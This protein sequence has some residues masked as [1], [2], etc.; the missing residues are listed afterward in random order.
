MKLK[1]LIIVLLFGTMIGGAF[2]PCAIDDAGLKKDIYVEIL[3]GAYFR[4]TSE[5]LQRNVFVGLGPGVP[6]SIEMYQ[7]GKKGFNEEIASREGRVSLQWGDL[8]IEENAQGWSEA[9]KGF[10]FEFELTAATPAGQLTFQFEDTKGSFTALLDAPKWSIPTPQL[11]NYEEAKAIDPEKP[12]TFR[13]DKPTQKLDTDYI[14]LRVIKSDWNGLTEIFLASP[15]VTKNSEG[16]EEVIDPNA[17]AF[18]LPAGILERGSARYYLELKAGRLNSVA[19]GKGTPSW[20]VVSVD[21]KST[22]IQLGLANPNPPPRKPVITRIPASPEIDEGATVVF[23]VSDEITEGMEYQWFKDGSRIQGAEGASY[24]ITDVTP[25][26]EG[27]Y[28]VSCF[29]NSGFADSDPE[30]LDVRKA[31]PPKRASASLRITELGAGGMLLTAIPESSGELTIES[32][33]D[34]VI[35]T[36]WST[37]QVAIGTSV[38]IPIPVGSQSFFR[39]VPPRPE[40]ASMGDRVTRWIPSAKCSRR[41]LVI[42]KFGR[43]KVSAEIIRPKRGNKIHL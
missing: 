20:M 41:S 35:W 27:A 25:E 13:W 11:L 4:Q 8:R 39:P 6:V 24:T 30:F 15:C 43:P 1:L 7:I 5:G 29:N 10:A 26:D 14:R 40:N 34:L 19:E 2:E 37:K 9:I 28:F 18:T 3:R 38:S 12:F 16:F 42:P 22:I 21:E 33:P 36:P 31:V 17:T 32:S 23:R